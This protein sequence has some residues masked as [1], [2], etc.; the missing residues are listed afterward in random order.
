VARPVVVHLTRPVVR[1]CLLEMIGRWH[2]GV[3]YEGLARPFLALGA[4]LGLTSASGQPQC[5]AV[6]VSERPNSTVASGH[7]ERQVRSIYVER[8][9]ISSDRYD[10]TYEI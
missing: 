9:I 3:R 4:R 8:C 6:R 1:G 10:L 5:V 7:A 2:C